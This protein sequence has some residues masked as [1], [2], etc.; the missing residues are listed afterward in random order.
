MPRRLKVR[1][2]IILSLFLCVFKT[3]L[4]LLIGLKFQNSG[5]LL[6]YFCCRR[7]LI[8]IWLNKFRLL[9]KMPPIKKKMWHMLLFYSFNKT[10]HCTIKRTYIHIWWRQIWF[11]KSRTQSINFSSITFGVNRAKFPLNRTKFAPNTALLAI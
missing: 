8:K 1:S 3:I 4:T 11:W 6:V 10:V 7:F 9:T 2:G 5:R